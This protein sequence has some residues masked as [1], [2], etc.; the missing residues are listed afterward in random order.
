MLGFFKRALLGAP[1]VAL[2]VKNSTSVHEDKSSLP[3]LTQWFEDLALL[4]AVKQVADVAWIL[5]CCVWLWWRSEAAALELAY[6][7][8][9]ALKRESERA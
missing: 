6:A 9:T 2:Q 5:C 3:G 4:Q 8:G 7:T 1:I